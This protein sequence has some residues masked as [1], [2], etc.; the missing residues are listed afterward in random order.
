MAI[1]IP[2]TRMNAQRVRLT[3]TVRQL[4]MPRLKRSVAVEPAPDRAA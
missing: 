3:M 1:G 2:P 4:R